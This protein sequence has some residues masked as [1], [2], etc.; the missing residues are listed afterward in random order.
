[1]SFSFSFWTQS[2]ARLIDIYIYILNQRQMGCLNRDNVCLFNHCCVLEFYYCHLK[3]KFILAW[4]ARWVFCC[5]ISLTINHMFP[6]LMLSYKLQT[7][8]LAGWI[9]FLIFSFILFSSC[10]SAIESSI[11]PTTNKT[12]HGIPELSLSWKCLIKPTQSAHPDVSD[13]RFFCDM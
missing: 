6:S 7:T 3:H 11:Q 9:I 10:V 13:S 8:C 4:W 12:S 5:C 1:M 2:L